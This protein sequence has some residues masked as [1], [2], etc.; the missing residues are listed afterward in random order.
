MATVLQSCFDELRQATTPST[1]D[2]QVPMPVAVFG[3]TSDPDKC[4][5]GVLGCFKHEI[6]FN[7]SLSGG[8]VS[9]DRILTQSICRLFQ[10]P[11]EAERLQ[12]LQISLRN[13]AL[14][15]DVDLKN[16][17]TQTA[18]LVAADLVNLVARAKLASVSR[19]RKEL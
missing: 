6:S 3:T 18:A 10:A 7:V 15:P 11:N 14:S 9:L 2:S 4:P 1:G 16:L 17:A 19:V 12:M 13:L 8:P 5:T